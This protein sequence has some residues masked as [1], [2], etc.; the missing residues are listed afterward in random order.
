MCECTYVCIYACDSL[1]EFGCI[2][3]QILVERGISFSEAVTLLYTDPCP[4]E[5]FYVSK[6]V[7]AV[8]FP[9]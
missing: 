7:C 8:F 4:G 6:K 3:L 5:G 2:I 9:Q 1:R